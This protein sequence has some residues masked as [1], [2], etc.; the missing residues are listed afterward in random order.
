MVRAVVA[1]GGELAAGKSS[2]KAKSQLRGALLE[3]V[4][5]LGTDTSRSERSG[6]MAVLATRGIDALDGYFSLYLPQLLLAVI[7]PG[8]VRWRRALPRTGSRRAIIALDRPADP[9]VHVPG[10]RIDQGTHGRQL[11]T[12]HR[13][14]GHFLDVVAGLPTLKVFG[15]AKAQVAVDRRVTDRYAPPRW[16]R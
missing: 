1:W 7:V 15:R 10:R 2:A 14:A 5:R 4:A 6:E 11:R 9:A 16:P 12:L 8:R 3:R 13:L